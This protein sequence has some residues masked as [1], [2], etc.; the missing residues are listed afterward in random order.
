MSGYRNLPTDVALSSARFTE[1]KPLVHEPRRMR[2]MLVDDNAVNRLLFEAFVAAHTHCDLVPSAVD[3]LEGMRAVAEHR[4]DIVMSDFHMPN[5]TGLDLL[6]Y[7]KREHPSVEVVILSAEANLPERQ[8]V[9]DA[10]AHA[11]LAKPIGLAE[12]HAAIDSMRVKLES[13]QV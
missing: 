2:V 7:I 9:M 10:G 6:M 3:G 13:V 4:P 8:M 1:V 11:V 12:F 5:A